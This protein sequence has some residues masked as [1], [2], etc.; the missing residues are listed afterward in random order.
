MTTIFSNIKKSAMILAFATVANFANAAERVDTVVIRDTV[1][2][3]TQSARQSLMNMGGHGNSKGCF[4][5]GIYADNAENRAKGK[6]KKFWMSNCNGLQFFAGAE[7]NISEATS[8]LGTFTNTVV[9]G[10]IGAEY[11][12]WGFRPQVSFATGQK[13]SIEGNNFSAKEFSVALN[14]DF[15][16][17][18]WYSFSVGVNYTYKLMKS[19]KDIET[20]RVS[21]T[22]PYS[23]NASSFGVQFSKDIHLGHLSRKA[24]FSD[25]MYRYNYEKRGEMFLRVYGSFN[26]YKVEK[27]E[28]SD[29]ASTLKFDKN[30]NVGVAFVVRPAW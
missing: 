4:H 3:Q 9:M 7:L 16:R 12:F 5:A 25:G 29:L 23:G 21:M 20:E 30:F 28:G 26:P 22:L 13:M 11:E 27:L 2:V 15:F 8:E 1:R 24:S 17:H 18:A 19:T 14:Y 6:A 10:R